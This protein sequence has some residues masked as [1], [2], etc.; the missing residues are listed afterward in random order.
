MEGKVLPSK[1]AGLNPS[2][3]LPTSNSRSLHPVH[4]PSLFASGLASHII[5]I[6]NYFGLSPRHTNQDAFG[7]SVLQTKLS[8]RAHA[9]LHH[10]HRRLSRPIADTQ[11]VF[12]A[13]RL[14]PT[15]LE[16][17]YMFECHGRLVLLTRAYC[18][19]F[20]FFKCTPLSR[21][22]RSLRIVGVSQPAKP[23]PWYDPSTI[24]RNLHFDLTF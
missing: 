6:Y 19:Q 22:Y 16:C 11:A 9:P 14:R 20:F 13:K 24:S 21:V 17:T 12:L 4:L 10:P 2:C 5:R 8:R 15:L 23:S 1:V 7:S 3:V 18:R